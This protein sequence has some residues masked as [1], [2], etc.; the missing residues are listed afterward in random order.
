M[1]DYNYVLLYCE[2]C[3]TIIDG[4]MNGSRIMFTDNPEDKG[5]TIKDEKMKC[6]VCRGI[7]MRMVDYMKDSEILLIE[8][9][10]V[11]EQL[12]F[13]SGKKHLLKIRDAQSR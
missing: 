12:I 3:G 4:C 1:S 10:Y 7:E 6:P 13:R 9:G 5:L 2:S 11:F 8:R